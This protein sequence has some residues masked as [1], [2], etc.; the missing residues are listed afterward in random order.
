MSEKWKKVNGSDNLIL[1]AIGNLCGR[2]SHIFLKP[3]IKW[4]TMYEWDL[5][6]D[7]DKED[8]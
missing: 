6:E 8:L 4:G 7:I 2:I 5:E 1:N 3:S